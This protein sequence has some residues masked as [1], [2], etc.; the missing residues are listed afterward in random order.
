MTHIKALLLAAKYL[1]IPIY[2]MTI[3]I[4]TGILLSW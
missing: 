4:M 2:P 1:N 3:N